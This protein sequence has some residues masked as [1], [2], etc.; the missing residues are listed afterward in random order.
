MEIFNEVKPKDDQEK[1]KFVHR[2]LADMQRVKLEKL[3]K[4]PVSIFK[5]I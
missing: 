2:S 5:K 4:N 3:M 1:Q